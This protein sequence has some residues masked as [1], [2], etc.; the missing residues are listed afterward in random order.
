MKGSTLAAAL[1]A[2]IAAGFALLTPVSDPDLFWH[3]ASGDWMLDHA[4][5]LDRDV[6]SFTRTGVAYHTGEWL[7][8]IV[9]ALAY[10]AGG[11]LG[12]ELL[13]AACV[14]IGTF[15]AARAA[16]R[17]Q[18]HLGW[19]GLPVL[20]SIL[21]SRTVWGDRPQLFTLALFPI[22]LDLLL[23]ARIS[24][25]SRRL[26]LLPAIFFV[27]ANLHGAFA[28]GLVLVAVFVVES[29][30]ARETTRT[31]LLAALI[32]SVLATLVNPAGPGA[33]AAGFGYAASSGAHVVEEGPLDVLSG[34]GIVVAAM[35]L[36]SLTIA[37]V[38]GLDRIATRL[39]MP[40]LWPGLVVPFAFLGFAIQRHAIL[41]CVVMA[42]FVAAGLPAAIGR[43]MRTAPL[44]PRWVS[45]AVLAACV[46]ALG[47]TAVLVAPRSPDLAAYPEGALAALAGRSGRL[48]NE[49]DWGGFLIRNAP[50]HPVFVDGRG[51]T[52]FVPGVVAD[53]D[54]AVRLRP[55]Y[56]SVLDRWRIDL[57]LVRP[58]RPLAVALREEGWSVVQE[59]AGRWVL[60]ARR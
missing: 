44:L 46:L 52:L 30:L 8:E 1:F 38:L 27:W 42:P 28:A 10:R 24:R 53:F 54:D 58:Q 43:P 48:L 50:D 25:S 19:A 14:G 33:L 31:Q 22:V 11:W 56:R 37:L 36:G 6:F 26:L 16:L 21:V 59:E 23:G 9:L 47:V 5:L 20:A 12:L 35:L 18:P 40:L 55:G 45:A 7:G 17:L 49:Y 34:A 32:A 13:R 2:F 15:F 60:L 29:V 39:G 41:A 57:V 4:R 51:A 3:L